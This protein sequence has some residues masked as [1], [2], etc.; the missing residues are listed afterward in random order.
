MFLNVHM[1]TFPFLSGMCE[2]QGEGARLLG[3]QILGITLGNTSRRISTKIGTM[4]RAA[5][6]L[7][8]FHT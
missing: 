3:D 7:N 4:Y 5:K 1:F 2:E 8:I 6:M